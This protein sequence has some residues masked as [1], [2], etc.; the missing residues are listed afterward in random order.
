MLHWINVN[1]DEEVIKVRNCIVRKINK[2]YNVSDAGSYDTVYS[3]TT[4]TI[5]IVNLISCHIIMCTGT[6]NKHCTSTF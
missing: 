1:D 3:G 5:G 6:G 2:K 4:T